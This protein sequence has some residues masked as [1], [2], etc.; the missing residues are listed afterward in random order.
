MGHERQPGTWRDEDGARVA[1]ADAL[2]AWVPV[3]TSVLTEVAGTYGATLTY[4]ALADRLWSE[5]G[6]RTR[7]LLPNW[8]GD[9]LNR[10]SAAQSSDQPLLTSLVVDAEGRVGPGYEGPVRRQ[11]GRIPEDLQMHAAHTRLEC[12]RTFGAQLPPDGGQPQ[13]TPQ[14]RAARARSAP[15]KRAVCCDMVVPLSG[16]CGVCGAQVR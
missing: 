2:D 10:V 1:F 13:L 6:I 9:V 7:S 11:E 8:I 15:T 4:R 3:A 16:E 12:Y 14:Q 5:T